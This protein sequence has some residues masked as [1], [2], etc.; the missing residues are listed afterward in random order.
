MP[1]CT[2]D[3]NVSSLRYTVITVYLILWKGN[4]NVEN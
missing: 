3:I 1:N 2:N 4:L